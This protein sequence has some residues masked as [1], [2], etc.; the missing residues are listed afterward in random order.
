MEIS[1]TL[2]IVVTVQTNKNKTQLTNFI[3]N[4]I[5]PKLIAQINTKFLTDILDIIIDEKV[6]VT[7][8]I[9]KIWEIYPKLVIIGNTNLTQAEF[10]TKIDELI[11][12][13]K[14]T[15][16]TDTIS[17]GGVTILRWHY[18]LSNGSVNE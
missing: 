14:T 6:Q 16:Q 8:Q 9:N 2:K 3:N 1:R 5:K 12:S 10:D 7:E 15:I 18:H 11:T 13:F 4:I 17:F